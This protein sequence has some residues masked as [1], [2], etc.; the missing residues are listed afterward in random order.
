MFQ[1]RHFYWERMTVS[2]CCHSQSFYHRMK[3]SAGLGTGIKSTCSNRNRASVTRSQS[4]LFAS[5]LLPLCILGRSRTQRLETFQNVC[6]LLTAPP[7]C[8]T[9]LTYIPAQTPNLIIKVKQRV[10]WTKDMKWVQQETLPQSAPDPS[11]SGIQSHDIN[12]RS[13]TK[14]KQCYIFSQR[15]S[16]IIL[17]AKDYEYL[18]RS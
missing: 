16:R 17:E 10:E 3:V 5:I 2:F 9:K 6:M 18:E 13:A 1:P 11:I 4:A 12:A 14:D 8:A 15:T 7:L